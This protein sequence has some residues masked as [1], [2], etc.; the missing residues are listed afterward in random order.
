MNI[1]L[2]LADGNKT[3]RDGLK[4]LLEKEPGIEILGT[5][6]NGQTAVRL[7]RE[8]SPDVVMMDIA[9]NGLSG[10][11]ATCRITAQTPGA[12][13]II[14]A[15]H[16]NRQVVTEVLQAGAAGCLLKGCAFE[17]IIGAIKAVTSNHTYL[18]PEITD[19][20]VEYVMRKEVP[21]AAKSS[22]V[23][24]SRERE[25][26]QFLAEGMNTEDIAAALRISTEMVVTVRLKIMEKLDIHSAAH[27]INYAIRSDLIA[28]E[29]D[30][31]T[32]PSHE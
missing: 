11:E 3:M 10:I 6:D 9:T 30:E 5:T 18:S 29:T 20:L 13:V 4:C 28:P 12:K 26:L 32:L 2:L 24:T 16:C 14:L 19:L 8:L 17:E 31:R 27:L 21:A 23:L 25:V 15:M 7:A 22:S 1:T